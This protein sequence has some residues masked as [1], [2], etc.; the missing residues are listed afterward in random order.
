MPLCRALF[1]LLWF[2]PGVALAEHRVALVVGNSAY[3]N[4]GVLA[5]PRHDAADLAKALVQLGFI[6]DEA[7]DLRK[8]AFD[9]ALRA[10]GH[11]LAGADAGVFFY[12]GHGLQVS[13]KNYLVP[14]DAALTTED[15]L[16]FEMVQLDVV[17]RIMERQTATRI[18]F[19]DA[20]RDNPLA[21][22]LARAMGT[23]STAIGQGLTAVEAGAG[24][25]ISFST[26][27]G[28]VAL[29]GTGRNSPFADALLRHIATPSESLND[30]LI[31]VRNDVRRTTNGGQVPWEH[32]AL[33]R[34]FYFNASRSGPAVVLQRFSGPLR[35]QVTG[36]A[37]KDV[38]GLV[39]LAVRDGLPAA[40]VVT[41]GDGRSASHRL[42]VSAQDTKQ[43][44]A[45]CPQQHVLVLT[46]ELVSAADSQP[47]VAGEARGVAC[48]AGKMSG[49][50]ERAAM[51]AAAKKL[52]ADLN[53]ELKR[54]N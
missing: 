4:T 28:N 9:A 48:L 38:L 42:S 19:L 11:K 32:S 25:L 47:S 33:T 51:Q 52:V 13:G 17:Q 1:I 24:T 44:G 45:D 16:D 14:V 15:A 7:S 49:E 37:D 36:A 21:R 12:A 29:D 31:A 20:C 30:L 8:A 39:R 40:E 3:V 50:A 18:L 35:V 5:N 41:D 46:Y 23:R 27:P 54:R 2:V 34:R 43:R 10:F 22:N 26:Q 53:A 6:V